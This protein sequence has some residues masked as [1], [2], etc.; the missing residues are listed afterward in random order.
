[1]RKRHARAEEI[2]CHMQVFADRYKYLVA[3]RP[4]PAIAIGMCY[5][6]KCAQ[7]GKSGWEGCGRHAASIY[8]RIRE[9]EHCMCRDWPGVKLSPQPS[10]GGAAAEG[11]G[12]KERPNSDR[13]SAS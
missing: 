4:S 6:V 10:G 1:M 13:P 9:G 11:H 2:V 12:G 3:S 7:C 5:E 8:Q